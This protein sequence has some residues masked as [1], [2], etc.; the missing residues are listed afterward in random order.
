[1]LTS[2]E[3]ASY[4]SQSGQALLEWVIVATLAMLA[5]VWAAGEFA[6]KAQLAAA[7]GYA[8]W[9]KT[10]SRAVNDLMRQEDAGATSE[11]GILMS[12]PPNQLL[13]AESLLERLKANG[14]LS[15][16]MTARPKMPYDIKLLKLQSADDC[17][18]EHCVTSLLLLALPNASEV[19]PHPSVMLE[20]LDGQ[21]MAVTDLAPT[22]L[23]GLTYQLPNPVV[24]NLQ[25]PI[26]TVGL[27]SWRADRPPP[28]V[29]LN[30]TRR[31]TLKAGAELGRLVHVK[32]GCEPEGLVMAGPQGELRICR[33]GGWEEVS[34]RH[35]HVRACRPQPRGN[36]LQEALLRISGF[37]AVIDHVEP[38]CECPA[39]FAPF[40]PSAGSAHIGSVKLQRGKACLRL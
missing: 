2:G 38:Q 6:Q 39:G 36:P 31:I 35:D 28:Y 15:R 11:P 40:S 21:A 19:V 8:H 26:G 27:L 16:S 22:R 3:A 5:V 24:A 13:D 25:L 37:W 1:M 34:E 9:L 4:K 10:A 20:Q 17:V 29:R 7:Q 33:N 32:D 18:Q 30:E 14:W 23:Q 12:L